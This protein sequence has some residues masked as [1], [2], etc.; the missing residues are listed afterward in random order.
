VT[1]IHNFC[2]K[3]SFCAQMYKHSDY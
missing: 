2:V 3:D 1:V